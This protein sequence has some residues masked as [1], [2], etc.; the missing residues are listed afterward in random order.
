VELNENL[1]LF[2]KEDAVVIAAVTDPLEQSVKAAE[3]ND[4]QYPIM[5]DPNHQLGSK[6]GVYNVPGGMD[7]GPV[8]THSIFIIGKNGT[9]QWSEIS[10]HKMY[11]PLD[12][13]LE[14]LRKL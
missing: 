8:D 5:Y 4:I 9:I 14:E 12:S 1:S 2:E 13:I 6:Y 3:E 11:V 7:M 10:P